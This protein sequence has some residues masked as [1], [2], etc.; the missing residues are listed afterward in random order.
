M[1]ATH[2][3]DFSQNERYTE[4]VLKHYAFSIINIPANLLSGCVIGVAS[5]IL[6]A[7]Y[8]TK[9]LIY[10]AT[11]IDIPVP[12]L[13]GRAWGFTTQSFGNAA[14]DIL[15]CAADVFVVI[16]RIAALLRLDN[17]LHNL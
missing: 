5:V 8:V 15:N 14:V 6:T 7:A 17:L 4:D 9:A 16:Y 3:I 11:N 10:A 1:T 12:T 2:R 13:A